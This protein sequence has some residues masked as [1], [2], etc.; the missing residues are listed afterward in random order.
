MEAEL[1]KTVLFDEH[2]AAGARMVLLRLLPC[3]LALLLVSCGAGKQGKQTVRF[4]NVFTG[5]DGRTML[6]LI[7]RFNQEN[8]DIHVIMQRMDAATYYNKLFVAGLGGRAPEVFSELG[9]EA[10]RRGIA[11]VISTP[12]ARSSYHAE[13][14]EGMR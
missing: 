7:K 12:F 14:D 3:L 1:K 10:R 5:P 4:W 9:N 13:L 6:K 8:P 2:V 11:W